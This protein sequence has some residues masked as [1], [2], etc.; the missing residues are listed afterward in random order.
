MSESTSQTDEDDASEQAPVAIFAAGGSGGGSYDLYGSDGTSFGTTFL[1]GPFTT[2]PYDV[3]SFNGEA[4]FDAK[5]DLYV[6]N[7]TSKGTTAI[8]TAVSPYE[9]TLAG[10]LAVFAGVDPDSGHTGLWVTDGTPDGTSEIVSGD[11]VAVSAA[12]SLSPGQVLLGRQVALSV[13]D[14]ALFSAYD[15]NGADQLWETDGTAAGTKEVASGPYQI[16]FI[17]GGRGPVGLIPQDLVQTG[18]MVLFDGLSDTNGQGLYSLN[19]GTGA[20]TDINAAIAN[21]NSQ[22][23]VPSDAQQITSL[24]NGLA[25][26]FAVNGSDQTSL[27]ATDGSVAGTTQLIPYFSA[28]GMVALGDHAGV[29]RR[30]TERQRIGDHPMGLVEHGRHRRRDQRVLHRPADGRPDPVRIDRLW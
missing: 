21:A 19:L 20:V 18:D 8:A 23:P 15:A 29:R 6:S 16:T 13:G 10:S 30:G 9:I 2:G 28:T 3:V 24:G 4:L 1:A 22:N 17:A 7:G 11:F 25:T 26:L 5:G 12:G 14:D 27:W